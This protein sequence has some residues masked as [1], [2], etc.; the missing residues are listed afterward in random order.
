MRNST[1]IY[2]Q[3]HTNATKFVQ[4]GKIVTK[5]K[6]KENKIFIKIEMP[7]QKT[8]KALVAWAG[9]GAEAGVE[10]SITKHHRIQYIRTYT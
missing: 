1:L 6:R 3:L 2:F 9:A 7:V 8:T 5:N 4:N 10:D